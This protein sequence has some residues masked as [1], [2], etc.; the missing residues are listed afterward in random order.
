MSP[1]QARWTH[2]W[3]MPEA[4]WGHLTPRQ[5]G[6]VADFAQA[7]VPTQLRMLPL[8]TLDVE[9][10]AI[11][12]LSR[13]GQN[14]WQF[15]FDVNWPWIE[16]SCVV[17]GGTV[18]LGLLAACFF[19][20]GS[21]WQLEMK[22]NTDKHRTGYLCKSLYY[23]LMLS[24]LWITGKTESNCEPILGKASSLITLTLQWCYSASATSTEG[25]EWIWETLKPLVRCLMD[26]WKKVTY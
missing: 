21:P 20:T 16:N 4:L 2:L 5:L 19:P 26:K 25:I 22:W 12:P 11:S 8:Q 9:D 10:V 17:Q 23:R 1:E 14:P 24:N 18:T 13:S 7:R 3:V 15:R 6:T